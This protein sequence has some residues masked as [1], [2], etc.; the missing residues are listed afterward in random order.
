M[1]T[2][3][4]STR[5]IRLG[6]LPGSGKKVNNGKSYLEGDVLEGRNLEGRDLRTLDRG[7]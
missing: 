4:L 3:N 1:Q 2:G 6:A 5:M 7:S